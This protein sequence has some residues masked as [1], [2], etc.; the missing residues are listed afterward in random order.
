MRLDVLVLGLLED[1]GILAL[2]SKRRAGVPRKPVEDFLPSPE[3]PVCYKTR[4]AG[5]NRYRT[6]FSLW[7]PL[8]RPES[9]AGGIQT[10]D[11]M[12]RAARIR[13]IGPVWPI[14]PVRLH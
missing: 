2:H 12:Y 5:Q 3:V 13:R 1:L 4:T 8:R 14:R 10:A 9:G 6:Y 7:K 11:T